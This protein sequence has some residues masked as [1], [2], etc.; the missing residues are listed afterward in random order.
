MSD[1]LFCKIVEKKLSAE[2]V[3]EDEFSLVFKDI[4]PRA[5]LHYLI[6]PKN[7]IESIASGGA[8]KIAGDL[9]KR[10]KEIAV[11][12]YLFYGGRPF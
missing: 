9:I 3:F 7:H 6:I 5:P 8:E 12:E 2:I 4:Y 11:K 10:A 1:C